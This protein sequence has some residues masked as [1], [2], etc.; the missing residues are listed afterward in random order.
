LLPDE[1]LAEIEARANAATEP[2]WFAE[3]DWAMRNIPG[4]HH[5]VVKKDGRRLNTIAITGEMG[6]HE[7]SALD[8]AFI[9]AARTDV[10]ALL[11][12]IRAQA[13]E[14]A[15]LRATLVQRWAARYEDGSVTG[16]PDWASREEAEQVIAGSVHVPPPVLVTSWATAWRPVDEEPSSTSDGRCDSRSPDSA[17]RCTSVALHP[18]LTLG[19]RAFNHG[20][21]K[22]GVFWNDPSTSE[23]GE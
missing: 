1:Q 18:N 8:S 5:A 3:Q 4:I 20:D 15:Q 19:E 14:L 2:P 12:H 7:A 16:S 17:I 11:A 23:R 6:E 21:P 9:A 13:A 10:P 22:R